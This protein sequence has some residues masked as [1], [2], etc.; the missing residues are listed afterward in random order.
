MVPN[1][2]VNFCLS[3]N[4]ANESSDLI[5]G[6]ETADAADTSDISDGF[7]GDFDI[8]DG[9]NDDDDDDFDNDVFDND[10]DVVPCAAMTLAQHIPPIAIKKV[11]P[12]NPITS[13]SR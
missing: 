3:R 9:F 12:M 13:P 7:D 2:I 5:V 10:G 1:L 11:R 4:S 8:N 6:A